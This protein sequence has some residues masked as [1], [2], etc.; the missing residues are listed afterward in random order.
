MKETVANVIFVTTVV[1]NVSVDTF[2][3]VARHYPQHNRDLTLKEVLRSIILSL[4]SLGTKK[5]NSIISSSPN[6][7]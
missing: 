1:C 6:P 7:K 4:N 2:V 5:P 3:G